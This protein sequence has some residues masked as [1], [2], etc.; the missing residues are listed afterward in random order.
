MPES[1]AQFQEGETFKDTEYHN[2]ALIEGRLV[3]EKAQSTRSEAEKDFAEI[4]QE[5]EEAFRDLPDPQSAETA[6]P[7][8]ALTLSQKLGEYTLTGVGAA[9]CI[10]GVYEYLGYLNS[11]EPNDLRTATL[12][13]AVGNTLNAIRIFKDLKKN[14]PHSKENLDN[15]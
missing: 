9:G 13:L 5:F 12:Y 2:Q 3:S 14:Y 1:G 4:D 8:K 10:V 11:G 6:K 15:L 7:R